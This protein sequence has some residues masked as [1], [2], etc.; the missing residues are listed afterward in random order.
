M[1][2]LCIA[3]PLARADERTHVAP[4]TGVRFA[5]A[6][7][8]DVELD[9]RWWGL[10]EVEGRRAGE[11]V[12][13]CA[14]RY[15]EA[16][17]RM[18]ATELVSVLVSTGWVPRARVDLVLQPL[19]A[20]G[21]PTGPVRALA[22]V[23]ML[24][25]NWQAIVDRRGGRTDGISYLWTD[26]VYQAIAARRPRGAPD[27][28]HAALTVG[29][30]DDRSATVPLATALADLRTLEGVLLSR[31][32]YLARAPFEIGP[33]LDTIADALP[34]SVPIDSFAIQVARFLALLGDGHARVVELDRH[35]GGGGHAAFLVDDTDAGVV[36]F[37]PDRS[38]HV[39]PAHPRLVAID[40]RPLDDW[41]AAAARLG[42]RGS[43]QMVR[44]LALRRLR[45]L[46]WLRGELGLPRG[47]P[48]TLELAS[49]D[50]TRTVRREL[51]LIRRRPAYGEWPHS[52][53]RLLDGG[54]IGYLRLASM[55][56]GLAFREA[57]TA[58]VARLRGARAL[59]IDVRGND[60]GLRDA[61]S[62]LVPFL[63]PAG[64]LPRVASVGAYRLATGPRADR[65]EG[66]LDMRGMWPRT[67]WVW[68]D[69]ERA[70][71]DAFAHVFRPE[72]PLPTRRFSRWHYALVRESHDA[73]LAPYAGP[74]AVLIDEHCASATEVLVGA[75]AELPTVELVGLPTRGASGLALVYGLH[76]SGLE[77]ALAAM[78]SFRPTGELYEGQG[79]APAVRVGRGATDCLGAS[80]AQLD[81]AVRRLRERL[82]RE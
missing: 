40:G 45:S 44:V 19:D 50:G 13:S 23:E 47:G 82:G 6:D 26:A 67:S 62:V 51:P 24:H 49:L 18:F 39:D 36:A 46:D 74:V 80:D 5:R 71:L 15:G 3:R 42:A 55:G 20:S 73:R 37:R 29:R 8:V 28:R 52:A 11:L 70:Y 17:Q 21:E 22:N 1:A 30:P 38:E 58:E 53:S 35:L 56:E 79:I 41:I 14:A 48:A 27:P 10:V 12:A 33:A 77:I 43:S 54:A 59:V 34:A 64:T 2:V 7:R 69:A 78:A 76:G 57:L 68:T 63:A 66:F 25:H 4:Y 72:W 16:W 31:H 60:G 81:L 9:S 61:L 32:A 75:L 65:P